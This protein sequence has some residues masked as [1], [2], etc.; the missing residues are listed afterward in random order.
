M[1]VN[2][3]G[4]V[5]DRVAPAKGPVFGRKYS[6]IVIQLKIF[7]LALRSWSSRTRYALQD[8]SEEQYTTT[9]Q[10]WAKQLSDA[11]IWFSSVSSEIDRGS[12][13]NS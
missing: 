7:H 12:L 8:M 9:L 11:L 10:S 6:P 1:N 13:P 5:E 4:L 2:R 3:Y